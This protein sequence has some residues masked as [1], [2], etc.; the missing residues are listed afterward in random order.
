MYTYERIVLCVLNAYKYID[1]YVLSVYNE[2][3]KEEFLINGT[4][5]FA[6]VS[7]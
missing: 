1:I 6:E 3:R 7:R 5:N 4:V 2:N